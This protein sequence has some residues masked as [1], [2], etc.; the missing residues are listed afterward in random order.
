MR[1]EDGVTAGVPTASGTHQGWDCGEEEGPCEG[2]RRPPLLS[3]RGRV[4]GGG[5]SPSISAA[6]GAEVALLGQNLGMGAMCLG[7]NGSGWQLVFQRYQMRG[8]Y[9]PRRKPL[10]EGNLSKFF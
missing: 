5:T 9:F 10:L 6:G 2:R 8:P 1:G 4:E 3:V 7:R